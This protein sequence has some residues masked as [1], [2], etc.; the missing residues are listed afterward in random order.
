[1]S[2]WIERLSEIRNGTPAQATRTLPEC[3]KCSMVQNSP[4]RPSIEHSDNL[5][6]AAQL[7]NFSAADLLYLYNE[8]AGI[9]EFEGYQKRAEAETRAWNHVAMLWH[10]QHGSPTSSD[11]CAGCDLPFD[12]APEVAHFPRGES[13]HA[14]NGF[15]CIRRYTARWKSE[16]ATALLGI[17][18]PAPSGPSGELETGKLAAR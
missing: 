13:I 18:I 4:R 17:G 2:R 9:C 12:G 11:L 1:M 3:S 10:R 7:E 5:N 14:D 6:S 16:A 15:V 8:R